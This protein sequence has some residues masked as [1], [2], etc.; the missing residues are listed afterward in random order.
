VNYWRLPVADIPEDARTAA[1]VAIHDVDCPDRHCSGSALGH[2]YRLADAALGKA[3]PLLLAAEVSAHRAE[4]DAVHADL[5]QLLRVLG[6]G[7]H[8]RPQSSHEVM[9]DAIS[10]VGRIRLALERAE[11]IIGER[12]RQMAHERER[13][14]ALIVQAQDYATAESERAD[15]AVALALEIFNAFHLHHEA[16]GTDSRFESWSMSIAQVDGAAGEMSPPDG[17]PLEEANQAGI[18][19]ERE[20]IIRLAIAEAER[21]AKSGL[22]RIALRAFG[23]RLR[24]E[25]TDG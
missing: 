8:A 20:R 17:D 13:A 25:A 22:D 12:D 10:E 18:K 6:M 7:D 19:W 4:Q 9:L 14:E 1:A 23:H 3:A 2:A 21:G 16:P 24:E 5:S 15:R 11:A